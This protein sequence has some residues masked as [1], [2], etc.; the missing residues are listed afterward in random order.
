M[1]L[2][3]FCEIKSIDEARAKEIIKWYEKTCYSISVGAGL[4]IDLTPISLIQLLTIFGNSED[5]GKGF[6]QLIDDLFGESE[7]IEENQLTERGKEKRR[8]NQY[9]K[10]EI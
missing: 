1:K 4:G 8:K 7:E 3:N 10:I 5:I 9:L 6:S 2:K